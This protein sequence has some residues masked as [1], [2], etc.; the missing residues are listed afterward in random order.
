[1]VKVGVLGAL[2]TTTIAVPLASATA[3]DQPEQA[4][5]PAQAIQETEPAAAQAEEGPVQLPTVSD[6]SAT[7]KV[8]KASAVNAAID[9]D[10]PPEPEP[11]VVEQPEGGEEGQ[12]GQEGTGA[13]DGSSD[14][15]ADA[16][17]AGSSGYI[18]P[19][20]APLTS[21]YGSRTHPVLGTTKV[22]EGVDL[23]ASCGT[24]VK[25]A[26]DGK[27]VAAEFNSA[28]GNRVKVDH[29][30]GVITGYYHLQGFNTSV[31]A[32][33]S[34]GDVVGTV[35]STGRSTGCHLHYAKMDQAGNY[36]DPSSLLQ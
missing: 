25:A 9:V 19:V 5:A 20:D 3:I 23:G 11:A 13:A 1:M 18:R 6:E 27:V 22:H 24:P 17:A 29:G 15:Q 33:V 28:S 16:P 35:G 21:G 8:A 31:G 14:L 7:A 26:A 32:E 36:S 4:D 10:A 30:N 34:Q 2:A 12:E